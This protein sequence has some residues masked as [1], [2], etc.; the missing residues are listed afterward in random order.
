MAQEL[1]QQG[2]VEQD[3][4]H[5]T[6]AS[7]IRGRAALHNHETITA[8]LVPV[9]AATLAASANPPTYDELL[10]ETLRTL[11]RVLAVEANVPP[12]VVF[13]DRALV[14]MATHRPLTPDQ[15]LTI[16][17]VGRIKLEKYGEPFLAAI[18]TYCGEHDLP[19]TH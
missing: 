14:E 15:F 18:R 19:Q 4:E 7:P 5:G 10:F 9:P 2:L 1:I 6:L 11:R 12:Y 8:I 16:N 17:G 3:M 13:S